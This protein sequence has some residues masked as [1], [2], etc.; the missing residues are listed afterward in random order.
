MHTHHSIF[1]I[2]PPHMLQEIVRN[3]SSTQRDSAL[4][5]LIATEQMRG[6]RR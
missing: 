6:Q 4:Q 3:G 1:C 5:T 2:I